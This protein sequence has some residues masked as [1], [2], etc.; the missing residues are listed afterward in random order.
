MKD[1]DSLSPEE[2]DF[3]INYMNGPKVTSWPSGMQYP[4]ANIESEPTSDNRS[5]ETLKMPGS[6]SVNE[7]K[8][9]ELPI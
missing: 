5:P 6:V 3:Y 9:E 8:D 4:L 2:K 7:I 1:F